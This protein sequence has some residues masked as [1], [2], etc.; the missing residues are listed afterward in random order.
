MKIKLE[1]HAVKRSKWYEF[2]IRFAFGGLVAATAGIIAKQFGPAI[3]VFSL[4]FP[5]FS[6]LLQP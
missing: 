5:L 4:H 6:P 2:L 1:M 3:E